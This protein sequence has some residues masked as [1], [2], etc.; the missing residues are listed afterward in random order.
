[1]RDLYVVVHPEATHH[2]DKIVGGWFDSALTRRGMA[3]ARRIAAALAAVIP[4]DADAALFSS[5]LLRARQTAEPLAAQLGLDVH[6][7]PD[8]R[9]RSYGASEGAPVGSM[10][11][12]PPPAQGDRMLHRDG[13]GSE[14]RF[15]WAS[16]VYAGLDRVLAMGCESSVVVTHGGTATYLIAAW[17]GLPIQAAGYVKFIAY[18]GSITHLRE[19]DFF[20]DR[21]VVTLND[22]DHLG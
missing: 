8:L 2:L 22:L 11:Y 21:Q 1:M 19:D 18:A 7:D 6:L 4:P 17:I 9:E 20:H 16:R 5:D 13:V 10:T 14:T 3:D 15:A 12:T